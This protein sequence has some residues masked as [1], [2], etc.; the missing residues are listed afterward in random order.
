MLMAILLVPSLALLVP[1]LVLFIECLAARRGQSVS[2]GQGRRPRVAVLIPAHDEAE[3]IATTVRQVRDQLQP[4]DRLLVVADNC[5]DQTAEIAALA[6]AEVVERSDVAHR[7][8]GFAL[9]FG[10]HHLD[11]QPPEVV[12]VVD[13]DCQIAAGAIDCL[14]R[15]ALTSGRPVQ[16]EYV[17]SASDTTNPRAGLSA[18]AFLIRNRVRMRG[19]QR[20]GQPCQLTGSGMAFPWPLLRDAPP[21]HDNL[22]E[23][24]VLGLHLAMAGAPP[25]HCAEATIS[26]QLPDANKAQLGQRRRW[27]HGHLS[28]MITLAPR[29][30]MTGLRQGRLD[31]C[32]MALD[33]MVPPLA[34]LVM[35]LLGLV[36]VNALAWF[37]GASSIPL[38]MSAGALGLVTSAVALAWWR[39]G[40]ATLPARSLLAV[41]GY[42]VWKIPLYL[43][44]ALRGHH[45]HW[46]RTARSRC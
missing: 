11:A 7:G 24:M 45:R 41:P 33:L 19:L 16:A 39:F 20:L 14:A 46:E 6:G 27:E 15:A 34:L 10:V 42:M 43:G 25:L 22:V 26:S 13:A 30:L 3:G 12:V 18:L 36:A 32:V 2:L 1:S 40:R 44:F 5:T 4:D 23:D 9:A 29:L 31:L 37:L 21:L 35:A 38:L 8:K 17:L 28:T